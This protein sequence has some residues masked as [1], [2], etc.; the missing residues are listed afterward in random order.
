MPYYLGIDVGTS[1]VKALL[2]DEKG[3]IAGS[4]SHACSLRQPFIGWA[5]QDPEEWWT[6][7]V[8]AVKSLLA[9]GADPGQ[10]KGIGLTGQMHG[11][12]A[13]DTN[14]DVLRPAI[15]WCDQRT[16]KEAAAI[17]SKIGD[18]RLLNVT[19]NLALTGFTAAKILWVKNN[20]PAVFEKIHK[21]LW[22]KDYIRFRLSG[23][24]STDISDASAT[25]LLDIRTGKWSREIAGDL[26]IPFEYLPP[27]SN[28]SELSAKVSARGAEETGLAMGTPIAGGAGDQIAGAVG[29]GI[30]QEGLASSVIGSSGVVITQ[31]D[32]LAIDDRCRVHTFCHAIPGKWCVLGVTQ[33][34]GL[35]L[36]WLKE[37]CCGAE[38]Y[39]GQHLGDSP[40]A[41]MGRE[42][43]RAP[44]GS[45]GLIFLPYLMGERTPHL[46][47]DAKGVFF[48]ISAKTTHNDL[49]R[50]VMEGV[51]YSL[52]NCFD[53][54]VQLG[55]DVNEVRVS[56][57]GGRSEVWRQIQADVYGCDVT[58]L[59]NDEGPSFGAAILAAV[60]AGEYAGIQQAS[61]H[62]V[63]RMDVQKPLTE[64]TKTY[65]KY[66][67]I[68]C[69]LYGLLAEPFKRLAQITKGGQ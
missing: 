58:T 53:L 2:I 52:K 60:G 42:A 13:L 23:E 66:Y 7:T 27:V 8:A 34:A 44:V 51:A 39:L 56:G 65:R 17:T 11:L 54:V 4:S 68:Y 6:A 45:Q 9:G 19:G 22:P 12:V 37:N 43:G 38:D 31:T 50:A 10:I 46:D 61:S 33:G 29:S 36:K 35:S 3:T 67:E 30:V 14:H 64:N 41:I 26:G 16:A 20:E 24:L 47:P 55:L 1:A 48:G 32:K 63:R 25:N 62:L 21:I 28:S 40:Y 49:I 15:I 57:G 5:E 18:S 69:D 59:V